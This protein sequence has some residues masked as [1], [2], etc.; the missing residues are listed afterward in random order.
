MFFFPSSSLIEFWI[1]EFG[2]D[3]RQFGR[4]L[5]H[6]LLREWVEA[7]SELQQERNFRSLTLERECALKDVLR[8]V[9]EL[10]TESKA[11]VAEARY[12]DLEN[13]M[14][15]ARTKI[16][17][18]FCITLCVHWACNTSMFDNKR[19]SRD[20]RRN[21]IREFKELKEL[22]RMK[23]GTQCTVWFCVVDTTFKYEVSHDTVQ[24]HWH[25]TFSDASASAYIIT[26]NGLSEREKENMIYLKEA[27]EEETNDDI[28]SR[29]KSDAY[30]GK[31]SPIYVDRII[32]IIVCSLAGFHCLLAGPRWSV[33][34][35]YY[36]DWGYIDYVIQFDKS[37]NGVDHGV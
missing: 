10:N 6:K 32:A 12:S 22:K 34:G 16:G 5:N 8:H 15:S 37:D 3:Y 2:L 17:A 30:G 18:M 27:E 24:A 7:K 11:A 31:V 26:L 35:V 19:F 1:S 21:V 33:S 29:P 25:Q 4:R 20:C 9:E 23:R 14:E 28:M 13:M 36:G